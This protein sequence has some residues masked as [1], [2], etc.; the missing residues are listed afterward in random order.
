MRQS[1]PFSRTIQTLLD[2]NGPTLSMQSQPVGTSCSVASG[3]ATFIGIGTAIFPAGQ[4][5]R[6]T[7]SGTITHQWHQ[8]GVGALTDG[9][10]ITGSGTTTLTLS[11]LTSPTDNQNEYFCKI[12]YDPSD[13]SPNAINEPFDSSSA[14]VTVSP[15]I[16]ITTQPENVTIEQGNPATFSVVAS[17]S[18]GSDQD[19]RYQWVM[20]GENLQDGRTIFLDRGQTVVSGA[21][22]PTLSIN[23]TFTDFNKLFCKV[24]HATANPGIVTTT[25][26]NLDIASPRF[27][28]A[29]QRFGDGTTYLAD[30]GQ[31]EL[32]SLG[33]LS[34]RADNDAANRIV[35][36]HAPESD[37]DVK[38]TMGG[39][40]GEDFGT[41]KGG[42]G[43]IS[44]FK[45]T[46]KKGDEYLIKLGVNP[47]QGGAPRGGNRGFRSGGGGGLAAIYHKGKLIAVCGGGGGAGSN[48]NGGDG[49]GL[50]V[51]GQDGFGGGNVGRGGDTI[52]QGLLPTQGMTQAGRTGP[53]DFDS[54]STGG[55]RIGGCTVGSTWWRNEG[56]SPCQDVP[57]ATRFRN[58]DGSLNTATALLSRGFK[59]GQGYINNG[60]A[61]GGTTGCGAGG[62]GANGGSG[63]TSAFRG[64]G[65][66][67]GYASDEVELLSSSVLSSGTR[68]G[69]NDGVAFISFEAWEG[70]TFEDPDPYVPNIPPKVFED[71]FIVERFRVT[72]D[73]ADTNTVTFALQSGTGPTTIRFGPNGGTVTAQIGK[74]AVYQRTSST[75][76][77]PGSLAF[78]LNGRTL[79]LDDRQGHNPDRDFTDLRITPTN[80][81][82]TST[83]RLVY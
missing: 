46:L 6:N 49:G 45:V 39:A 82:F 31:R 19:L 64:G 28:L 1:V 17:T 60:G 23:K 38:I 52:T 67:S 77:G 13:L 58:S 21:E 16:S 12:G 71:V 8:V 25:Q 83:T 80:G 35:V 20:D 3:I 59:S 5:A 48:S 65:G 69:G 14:K 70:I 66:A 79:E 29:Y 72:R 18:D 81:T 42:E 54:N 51:K 32:K 68:L 2:L 40:A 74:G 53:D 44:V 57:G 37:I 22:S 9:T 26:A 63:A 4:T 73:A 75:N 61:G 47:A 62:A 56:F 30:S 55:G 7:N 33:A 43:G 76:S 15:V 50:Q 27:L 36:V 34:F 24:S 78:R 41:S 11:G 10:N